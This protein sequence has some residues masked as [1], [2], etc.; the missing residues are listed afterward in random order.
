MGFTHLST[1]LPP[2][3]LV[4]RLDEIFSAFDE[5]AGQ[6]GIEKIKTIGDAYMAATGLTHELEDHVSSMVEMGL[7]M[8]RAVDRI[9]RKRGTDFQL[10]IGINCGPVVAGV[11]GK[12]KFIYDLWG[13]AVNLASRMESHGVEG[14]IQVTEEVRRRL[15]DRFAVEDRGEISV[16]GKGAVRT[17]LIAHTGR[18]P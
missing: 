10:R 3:E 1:E 5:S 4:Q 6:L 8:L 15:G 14:R 9:N 11:I 13:D 12:S 17:Y 7:E 2:A 16:K 18:R